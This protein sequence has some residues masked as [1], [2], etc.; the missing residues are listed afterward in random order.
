MATRP[1]LKMPDKLYAELRKLIHNLP[2][3][4]VQEVM[5]TLKPKKAVEIVLVL[6]AM[7]DGGVPIVVDGQ[8]VTDLKRYSLIE[9]DD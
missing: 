5:I 9:I 7:D 1:Y 3:H 8:I 6:E 2:E 4:G